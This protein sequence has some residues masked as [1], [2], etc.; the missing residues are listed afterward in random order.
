MRLRTFD[1]HVAFF[2]D[3][4]RKKKGPG[5]FQTKLLH[6]ITEYSSDKNPALKFKKSWRNERLPELDDQTH[7]SYNHKEIQ[8]CI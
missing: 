6:Y 8:I 4:E 7:K 3:V 1:R 5:T 2:D